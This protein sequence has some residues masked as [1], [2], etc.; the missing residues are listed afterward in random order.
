M[1]R[2]TLLLTTFCLLLTMSLS[3]QKP[4]AG[5][6]K[7]ETR[8]EGNVDPNVKSHFPAEE[9]V[10]VMESIEMQTSSGQGINQVSIENAQKNQITIM[11]DLTAM[12]EGMYYLTKTIGK[13]KNMDY[14]YEADKSDTK[15]ILGYNCYK[16]K[17][18]ITNLED[19]ETTEV[20]YYVSDDF[21]PNHKH[22]GEPGFTGYPLMT[23]TQVED[24]EYV[25]QLIREAKEIKANK[26]V[27]DVTFML[28]STAK[29][30]TEAPEMFQEGFLMFEEMLSE[31][32]D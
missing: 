5:T 9:T 1:K 14:K 31:Q 25:Y 22:V 15:T 6:V 21:L 24:G 26:K 2:I 29:P 4:F 7:F 20:I 11:V 30:Y 28:P 18:T 23:I 13:P 32:Y 27:K 10:T 12:G 19:D 3:A 16:V 8:A 17:C